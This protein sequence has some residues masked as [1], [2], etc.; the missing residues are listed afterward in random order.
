LNIS[1][2][3]ATDWWDEGDL[4]AVVQGGVRG[5]VRVIDGDQPTR[6]QKSWY[7]RGEDVDQIANTGAHGKWRIESRGPRSLS[8]RGKKPNVDADL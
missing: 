3:A 1:A 7:R 6:S 8:V 5:D 2:S 4:I